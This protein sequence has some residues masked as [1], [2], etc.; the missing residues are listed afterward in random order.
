LHSENCEDE[1]VAKRRRGFGCAQSS[2][3]QLE[4]VL[5]QTQLNH[6]LYTDLCIKLVLKPLWQQ[7]SFDESFHQTREETITK[8]SSDSN[9]Y[10]AQPTKKLCFGESSEDI[11]T[12]LPEDLLECIMLK[13]NYDEISTVR[14]V[15]TVP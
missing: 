14:R 9:S 11:I 1:A 3:V 12:H 7:H 4:N 6:A 2:C 15:S 13:L 5:S 8:R 10:V